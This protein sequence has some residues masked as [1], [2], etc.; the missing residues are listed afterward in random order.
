MNNFNLGHISEFQRGGNCYN[1]DL[2]Y[3]DLYPPYKIGGRPLALS[4]HDA[5]VYK[6]IMKWCSGCPVLDRCGKEAAERG[7]SGPFGG[8]IFF[9]G[10]EVTVS[11]P[12]AEG[13]PGRTRRLYTDNLTN[14][15]RMERNHCYELM[16][17]GR[18]NHPWQHEEL[19]E[20]GSGVSATTWSGTS[21]GWASGRRG[22]SGRR[23]S[24]CG[25]RGWKWWI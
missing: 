5:L 21:A 12:A 14:H 11:G 8:R 2:A 10:K 25:R 7:Y 15:D 22:R 18:A 3:L 1:N 9:D 20:P 19:S 4:A 13:L 16:R 23:I 6:G 24:R 17:D